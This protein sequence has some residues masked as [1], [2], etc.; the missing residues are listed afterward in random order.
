MSTVRVYIDGGSETEDLI[1]AVFD[2]LNGDMGEDAAL[3]AVDVERGHGTAGGV[4]NDPITACAI[5]TFSTS[6]AAIIARALEKRWEIQHEV[7]VLQIIIEQQ[8]QG[9]DIK[10]L[11]D[12]AKA[13]GRVRIEVAKSLPD[14]S[15]TKSRTP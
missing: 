7:R 10:P 11:V 8:N 4:V 1:Q 12:L 13:D 14:T 6:L 15:K 2:A 5:L 3:Y 9:R